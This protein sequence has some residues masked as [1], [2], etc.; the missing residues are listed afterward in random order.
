MRCSATA[1]STSSR[2]IKGPGRFDWG[3]VVANVDAPSSGSLWSNDIVGSGGLVKQ[4]GEPWCWGNNSYSGATR[5]ERGILSPQN[6]SVIRSNVTILAQPDPDSTGLQFN[7]GTPRVIGNVVNGSS[8]LL[9]TGSTTGT[10]EGNYTQQAGAQLMIAPVPMRCRSPAT[11][12]STGACAYTASSPAMC[13]RT[14]AARPDPRRRRPQR[15]L[16]QPG[17]LQRPAEPV[18]AAE[19]LWL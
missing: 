13:R 2:A 10:I 1:C 14:A 8:V 12:R 16:Q 4:G 15:H 11:P 6:G 9:T 7:G 19:Q 3:D 18:A 5:I 17:H